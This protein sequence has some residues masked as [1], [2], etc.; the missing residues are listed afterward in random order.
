MSRWAAGALA[1]AAASSRSCGWSCSSTSW[2]EA[3]GS[4]RWTPSS[5]GNSD[6]RLLALSPGCG[7]PLAPQLQ[8]LSRRALDFGAAP[9]LRL[10]AAL[11]ALD[12]SAAALADEGREVVLAVIDR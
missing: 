3:A 11:A 1:A 4:I 8:A 5:A 10:C 7:A 12:A 9:G 6:R 2:R